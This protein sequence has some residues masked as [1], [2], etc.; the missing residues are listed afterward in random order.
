MLSSAHSAAQAI[1]TLARRTGIAIP[2]YFPPGGE[3][4]LGTDLLRD[5]VAACLE[6]LGDPEY[7]SV[8]V[9]GEDCGREV[10]QAL[11]REYGVGYSVAPQN[12]GK[13]HALRLGMAPLLARQEL[14]YFAVVDADGDHFPS[15]LATMVRAALHAGDQPGV[16]D[17]LVLG[18]RTSR[19]RPMGFLR[20]E[21]E[22]LADRVLY[23]AL[24]YHAAVAGQP[25]RLEWVTP[26][27]EFPDFH[28]G[29]KLFTRGAGELVFRGE[30]DLC[31]VTEDAYY[32]HGC[33]AVM[34]VEALLGGAYL[35]PVRRTTF[36][37]QPVS[38]FGLLDRTRLVA[39][40]MAWPCK[41]LQ[42]PVAF[43]DQFLRNHIPRLLL[44]TLSPQGREELMQ[45]RDLVLADF[46]MSPPADED[47]IWGPPFV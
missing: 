20:G 2:V 38:A 12:R 45:I 42:V 4:D 25:L 16:G 14:D 10:A 36:N 11:H 19:H 41:R 5:T 40:K 28:S 15:E 44:N 33:E 46:G 8:S 34:V 35:V 37:E 31:G 29:Y 13:L 1:E 23:D 39:D 30:P 3:H 47:V 27:E 17:V 32:K 6:V 26:I 24:H 18:S 43:V 21:L 22:E 9:D 7:L